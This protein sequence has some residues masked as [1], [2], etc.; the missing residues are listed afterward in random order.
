MIELQD[1]DTITFTILFQ[2]FRGH[3]ERSETTTFF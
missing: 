1:T 2:E 3:E